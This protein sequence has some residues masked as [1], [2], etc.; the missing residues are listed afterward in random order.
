MDSKLEPEFLG[1]FIDKQGVKH[2]I[3]ELRPHDM[4]GFWWITTDKANKPLQV[5]TADIYLDEQII[6]NC[7]E[8]NDKS[9]NNTGETEG[10]KP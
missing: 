9:R 2:R 7:N 6:K 1:T 8:N 10:P 5:Y 4:R 3:I